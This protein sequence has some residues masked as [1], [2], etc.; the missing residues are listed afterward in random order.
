MGLITYLIRLL[1]FLAIRNAQIPSVV[2]NWIN[3]LGE[4]IIVSLIL[5]YLL[6]NGKNF[7]ISMSNVKIISSI[8]CMII[9]LRTKSLILTIVIGVSSVM[10][11]SHFLS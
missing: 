8:L 9:A 3:Y 5:P 7:D 4:G 10:V 11:V 1:P 2:E 6:L